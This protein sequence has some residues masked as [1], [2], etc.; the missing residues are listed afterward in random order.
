MDDF[1]M[2]YKDND[3]G[4][5]KFK[6]LDAFR[7]YEVNNILLN[8]SKRSLYLDGFLSDIIFKSNRPKKQVSKG[9]DVK[10]WLN[11]FEPLTWRDLIIPDNITFMELDDIMKTLWGFHGFH[12]SCFLIEEYGITIADN[13]WIEESDVDCDFEVNE[14][15]ISDIFDE[16]DKVTYWYDFGDN[17]RFDIEI[18]KKIDYTKDYVTI[19]GFEGKY[20]PIEDCKGVYGLSYAL[21]YAK[22]PDKIDSDYLSDL[23][24]SLEEFDMD[25][26]Q[27]VLENKVYTKSNWH[28]DACF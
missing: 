6:Q 14:T 10:V 9:Y 27:L 26:T 23:V 18:N 22:N 4:I 3:F 5:F 15:I 1:N 16:Y 17:W 24:E 7:S 28:R 21:Y 12:L 13:D 19:K 20:N 2:L 8:P 11:D 25:L